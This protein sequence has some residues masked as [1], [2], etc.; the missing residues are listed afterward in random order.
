MQEAIIGAM[1][2]V[3]GA[4]IGAWAAMKARTPAKAQVQIADARLIAP[5]AVIMFLADRMIHRLE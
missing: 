2:A 5:D 3:I 1:A 4:V